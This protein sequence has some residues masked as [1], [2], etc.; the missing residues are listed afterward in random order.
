[1]MDIYTDNIYFT[2][3]SKFNVLIRY[4]WRELKKLSTYSSCEVFSCAGFLLFFDFIT[5]KH[6]RVKRALFTFS[7]ILTYQTPAVKKKIKNYL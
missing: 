6:N 2:N 7:Y 4:Y 5:S 1:M 3:L